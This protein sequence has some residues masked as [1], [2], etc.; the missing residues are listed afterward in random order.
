M[1]ELLARRAYPTIPMWDILADG[2]EI[3]IAT[4]LPMEPC[5]KATVQYGMYGDQIG[6]A[7]V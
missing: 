1:T 2:V 4:V 7:H 3:G 5:P 6:R